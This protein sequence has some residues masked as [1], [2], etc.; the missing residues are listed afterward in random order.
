MQLWQMPSHITS[1]RKKNER[2]EFPIITGMI[3]RKLNEL[4]QYDII[5]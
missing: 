3:Y 2:Y 5:I 4:R 1:E